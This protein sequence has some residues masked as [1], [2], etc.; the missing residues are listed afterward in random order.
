MRNSNSDSKVPSTVRFQNEC[1]TYTA[2]TRGILSKIGYHYA[3]CKSASHAISG[4]KNLIQE[5]PYAVPLNAH[6]FPHVLR[7]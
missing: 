7:R 3:C 6:F 1:Y 5:N 2:E 4:Q